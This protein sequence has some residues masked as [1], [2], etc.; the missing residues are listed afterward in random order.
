LGYF[1]EN[2]GYDV[3]II[4]NGKKPP[5]VDLV[6]SNMLPS[7]SDINVT[8]ETMRIYRNLEEEYKERFLKNYVALHI[9][10]NLDSLKMVEPVIGDIEEAGVR[11][12]VLDSRG[13]RE[14]TGLSYDEQ[15]YVIMGEYEYLVSIRRIIDILHRRLRIIHDNARLIIKDNKAIALA[16]NGELN[17]D[18]I[19]LAAG[20]WNVEIAR[21]AGLDLPLVNYGTRALLILG[22]TKLNKYS[23]SD[24]TYDYYTRPIGNALDGI[25][26]I[27][28]DGNVKTNNL[29]KVKELTNRS[30]RNW[31]I[32]L[33]KKRDDSNMVSL[34]AGYGLVDMAYDYEPVIGKVGNVENLYLISGLDGYGAKLGPGLAFELSRIIMGLKPTINISCYDIARFNEYDGPHDVNPLWEPVMLYLPAPNG[35]SPCFYKT[36]L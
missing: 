14:V 36:K 33:M 6:F 27:A 28:G 23:I 13:A 25:A 26:F 5:L 7:T 31:L 32:G 3:T 22:K 20:G 9:Y 15:E 34:I 18:S 8:K 30:Y 21:D 12:K 2:E 11:V 10:P 24:Y 16:K 4:H 35:G 17:A 1:L 29:R 19:V